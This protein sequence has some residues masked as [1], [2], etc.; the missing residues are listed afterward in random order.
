MPIF[1]KSFRKARRVLHRL[2]R[3]INGSRA[4]AR[5]AVEWPRRHGLPPS[6]QRRILPSKCAYGTASFASMAEGVINMII[7]YFSPCAPWDVDIDTTLLLKEKEITARRQ[8]RMMTS[9]AGFSSAG[10][11]NAEKKPAYSLTSPP[12]EL[13]RSASRRAPATYRGRR[14]QCSPSPLA[15]RTVRHTMQYR[16]HPFSSAV[17]PTGLPIGGQQFRYSRRRYGDRFLRCA[18]RFA[19][20]HT[21][22]RANFRGARAPRA[23]SAY[24]CWRPAPRC[25]AHADIRAVGARGQGAPQGQRALLLPKTPHA[26]CRAVA[27]R[28]PPRRARRAFEIF[29][30]CRTIA[31]PDV[32]WRCKSHTARRR[33][34]YTRIARNINDVLKCAE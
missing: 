13:A 16:H 1:V 4:P 25:A 14:R 9:A 27:I 19:R 3:R 21:G 31:A 18:C 2:L 6:Q 28:R 20:V 8:Q 22:R 30:R 11:P 26:A 17:T 12:P 32:G 23:A 15:S 24:R 7:I 10:W 29:Q 33:A 5:R 34:F